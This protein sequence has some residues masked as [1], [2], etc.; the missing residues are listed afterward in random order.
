MPLICVK[1]ALASGW[2]FHTC[3]PCHQR[4]VHMTAPASNLINF[5]EIVVVLPYL[6]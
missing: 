3:C 6:F 1:E 2:H 4:L 5:G